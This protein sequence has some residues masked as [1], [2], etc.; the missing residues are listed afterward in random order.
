MMGDDNELQER[1][2]MIES[3]YDY[4][5]DALHGQH[6]MQCDD[7]QALG[8]TQHAAQGKCFACENCECP[9]DTYGDWLCVFCGTQN[10]TEE[11]VRDA[12]GPEIRSDLR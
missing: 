6:L 8:L 2:D 4:A 11:E 7:Y 12:H 10:H 5:Y 3:V 9:V 1:L